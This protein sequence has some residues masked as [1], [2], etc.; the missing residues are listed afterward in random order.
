MRLNNNIVDSHSPEEP[1]RQSLYWHHVYNVVTQSL[2]LISYDISRW[3]VDQGFRA[4][5]VPG[6]MPYNTS[7]LTGILSHKMAA[8]LSGLGWIGKSCLLITEQFGPRIRFCTVMTDAPL[9]A[10]KQIDEPCGKCRVCVD[11]CP[12]NAFSGREFN[13]GESRDARF[14]AFKCSDYRVKHPC[15]LCVSSCPKGKKSRRTNNGK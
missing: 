6:S 4:V 11:S 12:V 15:G 1:I 3:L 8:H 9:T 2:D 14:D 10:G 13:P 7:S 5:A